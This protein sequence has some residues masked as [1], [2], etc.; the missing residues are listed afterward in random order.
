M[1]MPGVSLFH[2]QIRNIN[3]VILLLI[4]YIFLCIQFLQ[5]KKLGVPWAEHSHCILKSNVVWARAKHSM[6]FVEVFQ[7]HLLC[8]AQLQKGTSETC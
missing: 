3:Y 7:F 8:S 1:D 4:T 2:T 6:S 5:G